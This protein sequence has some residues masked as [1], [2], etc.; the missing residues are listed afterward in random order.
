MV[1]AWSPTP[2]GWELI[3][4]Q[5]AYLSCRFNSRLR[6]VREA[7]YLCFSLT[8]MFFSL[9]LSLPSS[10]SKI[11]KHIKKTRYKLYPPS[12]NNKTASTTAL[13]SHGTSRVPEFE[14]PRMRAGAIPESPVGSSLQRTLRA[15]ERI[16]LTPVLATSEMGCG[17]NARVKCPLFKGQT[18]RK[19]MA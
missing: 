15:E 12:S 2:K 14:Q 10:L 6:R 4:S 8:L 7:S 13:G 19:S 16:G 11:N 5:G 18:V 17:G 9:S 1:G 3:H